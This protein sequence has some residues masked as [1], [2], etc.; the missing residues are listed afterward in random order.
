MEDLEPAVFQMLGGKMGREEYVAQRT[1]SHSPA[2]SPG[3]SSFLATTPTQTLAIAF[4]T[5]QDM[6]V[7]TAENFNKYS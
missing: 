2:L 4:R 1:W 6:S 7:L 5:T 3:N